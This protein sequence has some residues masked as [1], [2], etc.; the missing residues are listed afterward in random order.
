MVFHPGKSRH[1]RP[2][3]VIVVIGLI[4]I[5]A[6]PILAETDRFK[7]GYEPVR[8]KP[9][10]ALLIL[11]DASGSMSIVTKGKSRL[12]IVQRA[13]L[14]A[15]ECRFPDDFVIGLRVFG[16]QFPKKQGNCS[17]SRLE[18]PFDTLD[19]DVFSSVMAGVTAQGLTPI[20]YSIN[21][22]PQDITMLPE[23]KT[24]HVLL[25]CDG[26]D[27][28]AVNACT[29]LA[30]AQAKRRSFFTC[31]ESIFP[32]T[33]AHRWIVFRTRKHPCSAKPIWK[34]FPPN[35]PCC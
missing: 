10:D 21:Q 28:C 30:E 32:E 26:N 20:A 12:R 19:M 6:A 11:L 23:D 8:V 29:A 2:L 31:W 35:W 17:D 16:H 25:V 27:N 7:V 5:A 33:P 1:N 9:P 18:I 13:L 3:T 14:S 22:I 34:P 4:C 24:V 15:L